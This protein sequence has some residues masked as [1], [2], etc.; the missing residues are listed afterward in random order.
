MA[1]RGGTGRWQSW[2]RVGFALGALVFA[3]CASGPKWP[4]GRFVHGELGGSIGDLAA[5]EPGWRAE[6]AP[7][8]SLAY[9]H[10]DGSHASW[11][12]DCRR[13]RANPKA[14]GRALWIALPGAQVEENAALEVAGEPAHRH[15]GRAQEGA[16]SL[17]VATIARVAERC[18]DYW[19]L[20]VPHGELH[21]LEA[22]EAWVHG[23]AE[24][25]PSQ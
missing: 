15:L 10:V 17:R 24:T 5:L 12:R 3:A 1:Y 19:M 11:L 4:D 2:A 20:V 23:F 21:H 14:L 9:R 6:S 18:E 7:D 22:F 8:A 13:A 16:T 25:E